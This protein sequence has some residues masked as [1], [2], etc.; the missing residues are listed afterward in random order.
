MMAVDKDIP[1]F[2]SAVPGGNVHNTNIPEGGLVMKKW[3]AL[4]C[5]AFFAIAALVAMEPGQASAADVIKFG[6][7]TP[8]S[9][10]AA[11]WG[12]P[13]KQ[14]VELVFAEI[15]SQGGLEVGGKK[16][17]LE[18]VAYDHKYVIAEGVAT[19]NRLISKDDVKYISILGGA[20]AKANEEAV[21]EAGVLNLPLAYAEGL[22]S[23]KNPLTFHSFPSPPETTTFWKWVKEHHPEIKRL[24][25]ISPNDDTGWWSIKVETKFVEG[26]GYEVVAKEFFERG[27]TDF[28][29]IL[30]RMLAQKPDIISVNAAPAGSVGLIIK[31]AREL[32]FKGRFI[33]IGQVDTSVVAN[34]AGK[35]NVEGTWVHGYVQ[36]PLPEQVKSWQERYTK[37]YGEWNATSIDFANPAFAFVAAVKKAQSLDP[38]KIAQALHTV[39]FDNL[40][41]KAHFGGKDYYGI[42]NQIVYPMPFSEVKN[43]VATLVVQLSPPHN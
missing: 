4:M 8:L 35:E 16:Y 3:L 25:T 22:V 42:G 37:K 10:P 24:A 30:L 34:I 20:V 2:Y 40:W 11:P 6:I 18:V 5:L 29:P 38:K 39:E 1:L 41:G 17:K 15:N 9:G 21:N 7:S 23:D 43:G 12:I 14:A 26:L 19:V 27:L 33:H 36:A 13:H 31:Q 32:G 28:N